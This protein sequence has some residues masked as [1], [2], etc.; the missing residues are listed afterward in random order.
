MKKGGHIRTGNEDAAV[1]TDFTNAERTKA[2]VDLTK[3][4]GRP[5]AYGND[6]IRAALANTATRPT[7]LQQEQST[8]HMMAQKDPTGACA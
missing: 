7:P 5:V 3:S 6:A 2:I 4:V 1:N 8:I